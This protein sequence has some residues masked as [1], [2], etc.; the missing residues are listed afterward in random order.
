MLTKIDSH[1]G[2]TLLVMISWV[3]LFL[4]SF[5]GLADGISFE[6]VRDFMSGN[7]GI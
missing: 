4:E 6:E 7:V 1:H 5:L 3:Q 2:T